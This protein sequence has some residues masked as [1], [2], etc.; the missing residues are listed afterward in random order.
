M[1]IDLRR[2]NEVITTPYTLFATAGS[3]GH[4]G[5]FSFFLSKNLGGFGH[6]GMLV[7]NDPDLAD[8]VKLLR[9]HGA[10]PKYYHKL[11]GGSFRSDALQA[12]VLRIKMKEDQ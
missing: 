7:P 1:A 9:G 5:G 8:K 10:K 3:I 11:V 12:A 6:G 2:G 4:L